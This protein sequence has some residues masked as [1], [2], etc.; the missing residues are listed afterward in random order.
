MMVSA[1]QRVAH[2]I[3]STSSAIEDV[4]AELPMLALTFTAN[5]LP[6][7]I[8]SLSGWLWLAGITARPRGDL[9][10]H[11]LGGH[12][13][14]F[15]DERHLRGDLAGAGP[16]QL[17][18]AVADDARPRRQARRAG[19]SRRASSVYGP[20]VSYRSRCSPLVRCTRRNG[21]RAPPSSSR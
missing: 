13:L 12:A 8:G 2:T 7:I 14:A 20:D 9:V 17:G 4:T 21:T 3:L 1:P 10:A 11:Q 18:A 5:A 16:L 19:R 15:G 6:M